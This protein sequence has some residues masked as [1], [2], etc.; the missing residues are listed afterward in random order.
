M[1]SPSRVVLGTEALGVLLTLTV[2][3]RAQ[4]LRHALYP[5]SYGSQPMTVILYAFAAT[6]EANDTVTV[7]ESVT[8]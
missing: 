7:F 3:N 4:L 5:I 8:T 2:L 6:D 1:S